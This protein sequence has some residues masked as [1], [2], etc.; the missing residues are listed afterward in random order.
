MELS[1]DTE[2]NWTRRPWQL[3]PLSCRSPTRRPNPPPPAVFL[4]PRAAGGHRFLQACSDD[5]QSRI[6]QACLSLQQAC[7]VNTEQ[8]GEA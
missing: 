6:C 1:Q 8:L 2:K 3:G 7:A 4:R 5:E